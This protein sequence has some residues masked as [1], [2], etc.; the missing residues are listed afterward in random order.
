M[1]KINPIETSKTEI[2][3]KLTFDSMKNWSPIM[4]KKVRANLREELSAKIFALD[5]IKAEILFLQSKIDELNL[6]ES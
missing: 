3:E 6:Q 4:L 1:P 2:P 5:A